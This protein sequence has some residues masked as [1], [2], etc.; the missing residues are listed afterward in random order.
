M[1]CIVFHCT[2]RQSGDHCNSIIKSM[3]KHFLSPIIFLWS[4]LNRSLT[5][6]GGMTCTLFFHIRKIYKKN[7]VN[8]KSEGQHSV[9]YNINVLS[10]QYHLET[11]VHIVRTVMEHSRKGKSGVLHTSRLAQHASSVSRLSTHV[12]LKYLF[13]IVL[14]STYNTHYAGTLQYGWKVIL[15]E[16]RYLYKQGQLALSVQLRCAISLVR[17]ESLMKSDYCGILVRGTYYLTLLM[18]VDKLYWQ[19]ELLY[20]TTLLTFDYLCN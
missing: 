17:I 11:T 15:K 10:I 16:L 3:V 6:Y 2:I 7:T 4:F 20:K 19:L 5:I 12:A 13:Q 1:S 9:F 18:C 14:E 8:T